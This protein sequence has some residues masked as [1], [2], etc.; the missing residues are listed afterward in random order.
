MSDDI[1]YVGF[2]TNDKNELIGIIGN[3]EYEFLSDMMID[4][5]FLHHP[6]NAILLAKALNH[7]DMGLVFSVIEDIESFVQN[8][9]K[10]YA[11]EENQEFDQYNSSVSDFS[12]PALDEISE[13]S[14]ADGII[15]FFVK[16][17]GM[18]IPYKVTGATDGR[19]KLEYT[20][21]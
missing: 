5:S 3:K 6:D 18:G 2:S 19:S 9:R 20:P 13:P 8:F 17:N 7:F 14:V 15:T 21:L 16:H 10:K 11:E 4:G 12:M 1:P